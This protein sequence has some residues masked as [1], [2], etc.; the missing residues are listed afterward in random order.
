MAQVLE[1]LQ[2]AKGMHSEEG[3]AHMALKDTKLHRS[4]ACH[5]VQN[6]L[7]IFWWCECIKE[8]PLAFIPQTS[9]FITKS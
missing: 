6:Q 3:W 5:V 9:I 2:Q 8:S 7:L 1:A 4:W